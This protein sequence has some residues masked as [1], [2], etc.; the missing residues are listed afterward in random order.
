[1]L[2]ALEVRVVLAHHP[3]MVQTAQIQV[4]TQHHQIYGQLVVEVVRVVS[5]HI[6]LPVFLVEVAVVEV[7]M[8]VLDLQQVVQ[9]LLVKEIVEA[10]VEDL[11]VGILVEVEV[12][13]Q[14]ELDKMHL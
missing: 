11:T 12:V 13:E 6:L 7:D 8:E 10:V 5:H 4:F 14:V 1:L 3:L 2:L 9:E